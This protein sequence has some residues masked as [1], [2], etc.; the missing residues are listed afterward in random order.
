MRRSLL[1][2]AEF[3]ALGVAVVANL[4]WYRLEDLRRLANWVTDAQPAAIAVNAQTVREQAQWDEWLFPGLCWLAAELPAS[5]P[6]ILTG[7]S[8]AS[9]ITAALRLFGARLVLVSQAPYQYAMHGAVITRDGR[10]D[11][12]ARPEDA[13]ASS[14]RHMHDLVSPGRHR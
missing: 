6:V 11:V 13:F 14:V 8:R 10:A 4:Y 3:A 2:A 1:A 9:R 5:L 7:L 12:H